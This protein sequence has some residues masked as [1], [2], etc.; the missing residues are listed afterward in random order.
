MAAHGPSIGPAC[1]RG[2]REHRKRVRR[3]SRLEHSHTRDFDSGDAASGAPES[4]QVT[5]V[6]RPA[7]FEPRLSVSLSITS[8]IVKLAAFW[9]GGYSLNVSRNCPTY[10]CIGTSRYT[11]SKYQSQ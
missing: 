9:R 8:L 7:Y 2:L 5:R 4:R 3:I 1:R 10:V 6:V 11:W